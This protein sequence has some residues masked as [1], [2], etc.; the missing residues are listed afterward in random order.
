M[1]VAEEQTVHPLAAMDISEEVQRAFTQMGFRELTPIQ[2]R[3][4]PMM[5]QGQD[6]IAIA[7]TGTGKTRVSISCVD[8]LMKAG[9]IKNVLFLADRTSLVRQAH[10]NFNKLLPNV[11]T[12]L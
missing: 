8:V 12:S 9:W 4:I 10:K 11:T 7:P 1:S 3:C 2:Q 5:M 6:V